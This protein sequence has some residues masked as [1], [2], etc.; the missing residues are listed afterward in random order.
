MKRA[1]IIVLDSVGMGELPDAK[2]YGDEGANTLCNIALNVQGF[3]LRNLERL[4]LGNI[5]AIRCFKK[6]EKPLAC[7]GRMAEK[8]PGKDTTTGHWEMTGIVL[9]KPFPVYPD[10]FPQDIIQAFEDII[11]TKTIGNIASSGTEIIKNLGDIHV[12]TG[13]PIVYTSADSV[14]QI[15]A[16]ENVILIEK[17]YK[18]CEIARKLLKDEHAVGRV[19]ARPFKGESGSY[20]RTERRKDYSLSPTSK[21]LLDFVKEKG[22][23]VKAVGKIEDIFNKSGIT[24]S[25][26]THG[27]MESVDKT[28]E[29]MKEQFEGIIFTNLVDFDML[30]G[31]RNDIQGYADALIKFDKRIPEI[32]NMLKD[33]DILIITAD[34]GCD[35][36]TKGTDHTREY[37]PL[38]IFGTKIRNSVNL[39]TRQTF[40][41][42]AATIGEYLEIDHKFKGNSFLNLILSV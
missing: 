22:Q 33:D 11:G 37:V 32:L 13:Y 17:L 12:K 25:I 3:R 7:Y 41:D 9:D 8:S 39:G 34:H 16:H 28:L 18:I 4:G 23:K 29:Y 14:F 21:T 15:A 27:N 20:I 40:S 2:G 24:D 31:H 1:I 19:I 38:L 10:G 5:D 35:P 6:I 36:T 42:I 30:F 26:H